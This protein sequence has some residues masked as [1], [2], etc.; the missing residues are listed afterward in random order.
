VGPAGPQGPIGAQGPK[1]DRGDSGPAGA[2]GQNGLAGAPGLQL[3]FYD[4]IGREMFVY[5]GRVNTDD[6][7]MVVGATLNS[8][9]AGLYF[10]DSGLALP[11]IFGENG[12]TSYG[13]GRFYVASP[14]PAQVWIYYATSNCAGDAHV[15]SPAKS[16]LSEFDSGNKFVLAEPFL[17]KWSVVESVGTDTQS[18]VLTYSR[19]QLN[20]T[21][22]ESVGGQ[23][24]YRLS[25]VQQL[26]DWR[27]PFVVRKKN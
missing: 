14:N 19:R 25:T 13:N 1:G 15:L 2:A 16:L 5:L 12:A 27:P 18:R 26:P 4:S 6:S 23:P 17:G 11:V 22:C 20:D 10:L 21:T 9:I 7:Y 3:Y 8:G 24:A